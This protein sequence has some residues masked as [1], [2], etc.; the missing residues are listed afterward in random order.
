MMMPAI[1]IVEPIKMV[2]LRPNL[3]VQIPATA[4]PSIRPM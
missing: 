2:G 4:S 1:V 3:S